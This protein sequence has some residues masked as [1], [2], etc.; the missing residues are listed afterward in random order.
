MG[1]AIDDFWLYGAGLLRTGK[2]DVRTAH[3]S[4]DVKLLL[5]KLYTLD[6]QRL[7]R[8]QAKTEPADALLLAE[9]YGLVQWERDAC[10]R[11]GDL[12]LSW[13]GQELGELLLLQARKE[14]AEAQPR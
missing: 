6:G 4:A 3:L 10:G 11:E 7:S 2:R 13:R 8:K 5:V 9:A 12:L 1:G 14:Q